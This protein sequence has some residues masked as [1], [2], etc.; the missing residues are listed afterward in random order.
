MFLLALSN[1]CWWNFV[2]VFSCYSLCHD[3]IELHWVSRWIIGFHAGISLYIYVL[4]FLFKEQSNSLYFLYVVEELSVILVFWSTCIN[5]WTA[6]CILM[7][8]IVGRVGVSQRENCRMRR[9]F[10]L[11]W[12]KQCFPFCLYIIKIPV[13]VLSSA[14]TPGSAACMHVLCVCF[15]VWIGQLL[16][17]LLCILNLWLL[18]WTD[19]GPDVKSSAAHLCFKS[20]IQK[21]WLLIVIFIF[22]EPNCELSTGGVCLCM[23]VCACI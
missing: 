15:V 6:M 13:T 16:Y 7:S 3:C 9:L 20:L 11:S 18:L 17:S 19:L 1:W 23:C 22:R 2:V 8:M 21:L 4:V 14:G 10:C 12:K 5:M